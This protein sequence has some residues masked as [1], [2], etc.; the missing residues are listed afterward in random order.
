MM[1]LSQVA[2]MLQARRDGADVAFDAV[3]TDTRTVGKG[4]LFIALKGENFDG[5]AFV[6][7]AVQAGAVA[8]VVN[9]DSRIAHA[10]CPL[11]RVADTRLALGSLAAHWRKRFEIPL[12]AITGSNGKTTVKEMLASVLR[13]Y[14][15]NDEAVLATK[16]NLN[17]DIGMPLTLL[18]L[19]SSHRYAV[20]EM[21]MNHPGE[22]DYLTH[23]A[24]PDVALANNA[25]SAHLAGL[26][27]VAAV[28]DAKG[29]IFA[30]L[31]QNGVAVINADDEFAQK[32]RTAAGSHRI[33]D[34]GLDPQASVRAIWQTQNFG[35][36][37]EV[38]TPQGDFTVELQ[39]P[40]VHNVRNAL[41]ATAA[42]IA[43]NVPLAAIAS[44]LKNFGGV[45]GRLQRKV[46]LHGAVLIDDTYNAN[47]ASLRAALKVLAQAQGKRILVLGDMGE[48]GADAPRFH[49]EIGAEAHALGIQK[50]LAL[51]DLSAYAVDEFGA[52]GTH[53]KRIE[54]ML[55]CLEQNL[56]ADSTVL[57]KGSRFMKMERVVQH[58]TALQ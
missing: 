6:A 1:L 50:L 32:W 19:R 58:C 21:G 56:D 48:L 37:M 29:E 8:A 16:G 49:A 38:T 12:V 44:G 22:I 40:G 46:A 51:G 34:F 41:A 14:A 45:A 28:A 43:L 7:N 57:V 4:D 47:P 31:A 26:G 35:A 23:L 17:N 18:K 9:A 27:T 20:I 24:C 54:D 52:G 36:Q 33:V 42:A 3:S 13:S 11:L 30:G 55:T 25:A 39:V 5:A 10:P 15:G 2:E 53:F